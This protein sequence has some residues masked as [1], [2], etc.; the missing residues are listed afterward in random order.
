MTRLSVLLVIF[1]A[2]GC[3]LGAQRSA[4][5]PPNFVILLSDDAGFRDFGFQPG[6]RF[7]GF[8]PRLD[9]LAGEGVHFTQ[10]SVSGAVCSPSRAGMLTGRYQQR[11]GHEL[12]LPPGHALGL[13][14]E[15]RTIA[16]HLR[17]RGYH[18]G[19][20]GKWHLG[21]GPEYHPNRRGF[22]HFHGFLQGARPYFPLE[23]PSLWQVVQE[24]NRVTREVGY[25]TDRLGDAAARY[26]ESRAERG[27]FFLFVSFSAVHTPLQADARRL[28]AAARVPRRRRRRLAAMTLALDQNVGKVLDALERTAVAAR[29][30]VVFLNDNG[31][32]TRAGADNGPLRGRKGQVWE[33]G[34][35]VPLLVRWPGRYPAG[36]KIEQP[37][38]ALDLLPTFLAAAP[39]GP[40]PARPLDGL[41]LT[42]LVAGR[43]RAAFAAR[44]L[45]WRLRGP[46]SRL[47]VRRGWR[48]LIRDREEERSLLF[49]LRDDP[50]EE[51]DLA[52]EHPEEAEELL[53]LATEWEGGLSAP[54]WSYPQ[55]GRQRRR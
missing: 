28:Q 39:P 24:N 33:G 31:G 40:P 17:D 7:A 19:L 8:T 15:E 32:Q 34:V 36:K 12:N 27:P 45:F 54:L 50:G 37:V 1:L 13:P 44:P 6:S 9:R 48:K 42:P 16:D 21:Y 26:V 5:E 4:T 25:V 49:D 22:A 10:A 30:V 51:R 53:R 11:F 23:R 47:A 43:T 2:P 35:R 41:D 14:L 52:V 55:P 29:T 20:I 18:T 38:S 46:G 3:W